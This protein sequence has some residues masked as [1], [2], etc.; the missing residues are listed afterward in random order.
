[1]T[2]STTPSVL[3]CRIDID[4]CSNSLRCMT[5]ALAQTRHD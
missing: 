3:S 4:P 1:V 5:T 2:S